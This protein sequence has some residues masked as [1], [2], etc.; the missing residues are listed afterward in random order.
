MFLTDNLQRVGYAAGHNTG[1]GD[2]CPACNDITQRRGF[3]NKH[4]HTIDYRAGHELDKR[5]AYTIK[6]FDD[7]FY[8]NN[9]RSEAEGADKVY[10]SPL[11]IEKPSLMQMKYIPTAATATLMPCSRETERR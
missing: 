10:K 8:S 3:K 7:I 11:L 5:Q 4:Q 1:I 2:R 9:L 6:V